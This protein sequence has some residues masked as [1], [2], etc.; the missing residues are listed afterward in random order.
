MFHKGFHQEEE[1]KF[2]KLKCNICNWIYDEELGAEKEGIEPKTK[3]KDIPQDWV[4]PVCGAS[5]DQFEMLEI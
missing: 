2:K 1:M 4:C 5:K 3:W